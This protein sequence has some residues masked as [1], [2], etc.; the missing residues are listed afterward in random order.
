MAQHFL[1]S[2]QART[3]SLKSIYKM[4]EDQAYG[5]FCKLRWYETGGVPVCPRCNCAESYDIKTRRRHKCKACHHQFSVTSSSI[6]ASRKMGFVDLLA[7]ICTFI[8]AVKGISSLQLSRNLDCQYKTAFVLPHKM[9]EAMAFEVHAQGRLGDHVEVDG[10]QFGSH[11]RPANHAE[12]RVDRRAKK[13]QTG[14]R[15]IVIVLRERRGRTLPFVALSESDGVDL[16]KEH[17]ELTATISADEAAC[18]DKLYSRWD[19]ERINHSKAYSDNGIHTN[20]AESYFSRLRAMVGGQHHHVSP[21]YLHQYADNAAWLEDNR[22][23]S[24]GVNAFNLLESALLSPVSRA[25]KG[26]WQRALN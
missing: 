2:A 5:A 22:S 15:R 6:F 23:K 7:A 13:H 3:L 18:W 4:N 21:Q 17:V 11:I 10:A 8:N 24:N 25:W 9:R 14:K 16:V 1:L 19:V 20:M 12:N 26:Y